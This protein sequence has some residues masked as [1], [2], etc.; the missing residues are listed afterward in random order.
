MKKNDI[1]AL[2]V[3]VIMLAIAIVTGLVFI[4]PTF[5]EFNASIPLNNGFLFI[6]LSVLG[7]IL[8][9]ATIIE[10]GHVIGAKVGGYEIYSVCVLWFSLKKRKGKMRFRIANFDGLTGETKVTPKDVSKSNPKP[11]IYFPMLF[12]LLEVI[13]NIFLISFAS[14]LQ[15][16]NNSWPWWKAFAIV[17]LAAAFMIYIYQI[18]PAQLD[19]K[20]DGYLFAIL[21]NQ[22]NKEAYNNMLLSEYKMAIGEEVGELPVYDKV[23]DYTSRINDLTFYKK[24]DNLEYAEAIAICEKTISCENDVSDRVFFTAVSNKVSLMILSNQ[25]EEAREYWI[26]QKHDTKKTVLT[27]FNAPSV[28]AYML[29]SAI[30]DASE[31]ETKRALELAEGSIRTSATNKK[32]VE[33]KLINISFDEIVKAHPDWDLSEYQDDPEEK[34]EEAEEEE[35]SE[36]SAE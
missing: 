1:N 4:R 32:S 16:S 28:R 13:A 9:N 36:D 17:F 23:T 19:N 6:L 29:I 33:E 10:L 8:F 20:N 3:Y 11:A 35:E 14:V 12:L 21:T 7:S 34:E 15:D 26:S 18:F 27:G 5:A 22:T 31:T 2:V 25:I 24:L 30:L